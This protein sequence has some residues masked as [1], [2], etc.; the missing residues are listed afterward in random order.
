MTDVK[1]IF[2]SRTVWANLLGLACIALAAMGVDTGSID[3]DRAAEIMA[4]LVAGLSFFA[5]TVF[6]IAATKRLGG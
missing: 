6:R 1:S 2:A 4:Q 3:I 5:S